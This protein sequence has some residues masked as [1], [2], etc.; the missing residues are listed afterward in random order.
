MILLAES[1]LARQNPSDI[2]DLAPRYPIFKSI[3]LS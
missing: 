3:A 1:I 2:L